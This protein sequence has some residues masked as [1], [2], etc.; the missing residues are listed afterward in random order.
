MKLKIKHFMNH[1]FER[2]LLIDKLHDIVHSQH[3]YDVRAQ[4]LL[5]II[6]KFIA[7]Q[8]ENVET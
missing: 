6:K 2:D 8:K 1:T 7:T 3:T 5:N 4:Q